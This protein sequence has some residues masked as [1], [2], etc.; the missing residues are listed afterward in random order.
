[1]QLGHPIY[2]AAIP[3][4]NE[5][6]ATDENILP[7]FQSGGGYTGYLTGGWTGVGSG[8]PSAI[9][10]MS[11]SPTD[12]GAVYIAPNI[13]FD[14]TEVQVQGKTPAQA[15]A[16]WA[17][18]FKALT[19]NGAGTP[20]VVWPIHDYG[21][22]AW[23][24]NSPFTT[25]MYTDFIAQ[26]YASNYEFVTLEDFASRIAASRRRISATRPQAT[27]SRRRSPRTRRRPMSVIWRSMSWMAARR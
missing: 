14:F 9:G 10:Y 12:Q 24:K 8:Y 16:D 19:A 11:P 17:A 20:V 13:K 22:A 3:G 5:T 23:G 6:Y 25:Q 26:A 27:L 15:E 1:M 2:G 21:A 4:A 18:Q 7:Y